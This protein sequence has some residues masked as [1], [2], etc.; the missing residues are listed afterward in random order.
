L[1]PPPI[2]PPPIEPPPMVPPPIEPPPI[3]PLFGILDPYPIPDP[4]VLE[5]GCTIVLGVGYYG[6]LT[7]EPASLPIEEFI[8]V[9]S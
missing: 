1:V 9:V 2:E 7:G 5:D 6:I 3:V 4:I 8:D